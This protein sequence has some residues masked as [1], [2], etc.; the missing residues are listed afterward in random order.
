MVTRTRAISK[1]LLRLARYLDDDAAVITL[2]MDHS[3]ILTVLHPPP[4]TLSE[5]DPA[6]AGSRLLLQSAN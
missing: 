5:R 4:L 3:A 6:T 1:G 2:G